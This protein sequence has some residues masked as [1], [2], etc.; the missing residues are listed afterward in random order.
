MGGQSNATH[1]A[2]EDLTRARTKK[3]RDGYRGADQS[4]M[5]TVLNGHLKRAE[6]N[7]LPCEEWSTAQLQ[8]F[9]A[10]IA[11]HRSS[12]LQQVYKS[13]QDRRT[14]HTEALDELQQQW[15]KLNHIVGNH[16]HLYAPQ[17]EAHCR[18]AVMWW[19]HHLAED[20]RATFRTA[21][22]TVP[23]LPEG[24]K[25]TCGRGEGDEEHHVCLFINEK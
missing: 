25:K 19:T 10:S 18:E 3:P 22:I 24:P 9:M 16:P 7:T 5:S 14:M 2:K 13:S 15:S 11:N 1:A 8:Q 21:N 17:Q 4:T 12:E 20:T 23:L 6:K